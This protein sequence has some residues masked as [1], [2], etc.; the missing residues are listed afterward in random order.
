[1]ETTTFDLAIA[2]ARCSG[3]VMPIWARHS[4]MAHCRRSGASATRASIASRRPARSRP[5]GLLPTRSVV[6]AQPALAT[7]GSGS[8]NQVPRSASAC[9]LFFTTSS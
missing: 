3:W 9:G 5:S 2:R 1:M 7:T 8:V 6:S 4:F